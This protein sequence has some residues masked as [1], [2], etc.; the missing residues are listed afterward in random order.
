MSNNCW[1]YKA[2]VELEKEYEDGL[3]TQKEFKEA[4]RD[5]DMEYDD[6]VRLNRESEY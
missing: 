2:V 3:L 1:Y 4:M 5:L 6:S